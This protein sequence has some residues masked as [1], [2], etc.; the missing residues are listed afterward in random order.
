MGPSVRNFKDQ[1]SLQIPEIACSYF[2]EASLEFAGE[3][4]HVSP[5]LG[6]TLF[7]PRSLDI[8]QRHPS[9]IKVGFV[10]SGRSIESAKSWFTSCMPGVRGDENNMDFPGFQDD[11]GFFSKLTMDDNWVV[12]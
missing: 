4:E 9:S 8:S 10:G 12:L 6:I 7:G 5:Q 3:R 1:S 2:D 11:R